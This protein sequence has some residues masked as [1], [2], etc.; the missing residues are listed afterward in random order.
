MVS[1]ASHPAGQ[2]R[3]RANTIS[4]IDGQ[5]VQMVVAGAQAS[6]HNPGHVRHPSLSGLPHVDHSHIISGM[7]AALNQRGMAHTL[8]KH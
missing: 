1:G 7:A 2:M 4:H 5:T 8:P 3:P 6:R